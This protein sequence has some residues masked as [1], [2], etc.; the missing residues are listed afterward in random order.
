MYKKIITPLLW[1]HN[2]V[3]IRRYRFGLTA[4]HCFGPHRDWRYIWATTGLLYGCMVSYDDDDLY[5]HSGIKDVL[6]HPSFGGSDSTDAGE[7]V[8]Y[9]FNLLL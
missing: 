2:D 8:L 7:R 5:H 4:D 9:G 6:I 1:Y 3:K